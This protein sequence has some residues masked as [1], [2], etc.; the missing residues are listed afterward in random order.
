VAVIAA[1]TALRLVLAAVVGLGV[2]ETYTLSVAHDLQLSYYDHPPLQYWITHACLPV[3]GDGR[4]ARL[5]FIALF[6]GSSWLLYRLTALLFGER[7]GAL[8]VL[9]LN[10]SGFFT[11]AAG[12]W[13]LPD[14]P[15]LLALLGAALALGRVL[16]TAGAPPSAA[17]RGWLLAGAWLGVAALA[18][19]HA[20][21][22]AAGVVLFLASEPDRRRLLLQ[23]GPWLAGLVATLIA[24][25]VIAWNLRHHWASV[26]YQLGR[27]GADAGP[28]PEYVLANVLGQALWILPWIFVPLLAVGWRALRTGPPAERSWYCACLALP[29]VALFSIVPLLGRLG[30]PHWAMPGWLMLYPLLGEYAERAL[31]P[32]RVRRVAIACVLLVTVLAAVLAAQA[33]SGF[34]RRLVPGLFAHGDPTLDAFEWRALPR[35]LAARGLPQPGMFMITT[36]WIYAGRIDQAF[37]GA[38]PLVVFGNNPKQ[39]ALRYDPASFLGQDALVVA[40]ADAMP[41][42]AAEIAPYFDGVEELPPLALGRSGMKE[43]E[44]HLLRA[45]RLQR[46]LPAPRWCPHPPSCE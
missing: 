45:Q 43:I 36:S 28:H 17:L 15:L 31:A 9:A 5:P 18:K 1:F 42:V 4:A 6:A 10:V 44:L 38:V 34:G 7:A 26:A 23:P 29:T 32:V 33:A 8:A 19:Y 27:S 40:P 20:L 24:T 11:V 25:P 35:E 30:L 21:L 46:V 41:G 12:G 22:F 2:D 37:H 39:Y 13:V 14:G 3:L 16:F